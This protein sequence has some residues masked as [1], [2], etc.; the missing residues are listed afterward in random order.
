MFCSVALNAVN[1][2]W[3]RFAKKVIYALLNAI[4]MQETIRARVESVLY[5]IFASN[6]GVT[7]IARL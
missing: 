5:I 3:K 4:A 6:S 7:K 1:R 2:A